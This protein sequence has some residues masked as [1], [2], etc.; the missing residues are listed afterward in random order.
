[1]SPWFR[2]LLAVL[3]V[4]RTTHLLTQEDGPW[5]LVAHLRESLGQSFW[6]RLMDCFKCLSLWISVPFAFFIGGGWIQG[7]VAWLALSGAAILLEGRVQEPVFLEEGG[8]HGLLRQS[9]SA[10]SA[11][12]SG[13]TE[14]RATA[15][16]PTA[17]GPVTGTPPAPG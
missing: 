2:F 5:D 6:G 12:Q 13:P 15:S 10:S 4:W 9:E 7:A 11:S 3:A 8:Q 1:M 14:G 16:D 17:S